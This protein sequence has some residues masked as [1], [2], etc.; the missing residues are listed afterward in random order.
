MCISFGEGQWKRA[1]VKS[2]RGLAVLLDC[3]RES[4]KSAVLKTGADSS[5][6]TTR[7]PAFQVLK[8]KLRQSSGN[9]L[10]KAFF[11]KDVVVR[12]LGGGRRRD[13]FSSGLENEK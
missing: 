2:E 3:V 4:Q 10:L 13:G 12:H 7:K 11:L 8:L 1:L 6:K 9:A 5:R